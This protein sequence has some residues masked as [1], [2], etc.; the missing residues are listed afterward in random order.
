[1]RRNVR[2]TVEGR[3]SFRA[4]SSVVPPTIKLDWTVK[5]AKVLKPRST[6]VRKRPGVFTAVY[7]LS[8]TPAI[9]HSAVTANQTRA[10]RGDTSRSYRPA[11][12]VIEHDPAVTALPGPRR[13]VRPGSPG[14]AC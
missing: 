12:Q 7:T 13:P 3:S 8:A 1:M 10:H 5:N 6:P 14:P 9:T 2:N 11:G 4:S